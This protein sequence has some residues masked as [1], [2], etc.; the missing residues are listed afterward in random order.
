MGGNQQ[1]MSDKDTKNNGNNNDLKTKIKSEEN[2][3]GDIKTQ[4]MKK[5][6][7]PIISTKVNPGT[8][9]PPRHT[10][11]EKRETTDFVGF[12]S[13][14]SQ[15]LRK[16]N[17][18][19]RLRIAV[20][21]EKGVGKSSIMKTLLKSKIRNIS[22]NKSYTEYSA[23]ETYLNLDHH[24]NIIEFKGY[25]ETANNTDIWEPGVKYFE[26]QLENYFE[27]EMK[28][29]RG[30]IE[31]KRGDVCLYLLPPTG[32]GVKKIDMESLKRIQNF[33][34]VIPCVAKADS[35]IEEELF[36][37]KQQIKQQLKQN[38]VANHSLSPHLSSKMPLSL[39]GSNTSMETK[40]GGSIQVRKYPWGTV[41]TEDEEICDNTCLKKILFSQ[42]F[43]ELQ[44]VKQRI[45]YENYR[46]RKLSFLAAIDEKMIN[47]PNKNPLTVL[48]DEKL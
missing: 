43:Q 19:L 15:R 9:N 8:Q 29:E 45:I 24:V 31:D 21:G 48:E 34:T 36:E 6:T 5:Q 4:H 13:Y 20:M 30:K 7:N 1:I 2:L 47:I 18:N 17:K 14:Q 27:W 37:L 25:G 42:F 44:N 3:N 28:A 41:N 32:H 40:Y 16:R 46:A 11:I 22:Q 38:K 10:Q 26:S 33:V 23:K 12:S 35:F 39:I